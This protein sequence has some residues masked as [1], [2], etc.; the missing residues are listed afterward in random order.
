MSLEMLEKAIKTAIKR[1]DRRTFYLG[2]IGIR[3]DGAVVHAR[4]ES[5]EIPTPAVHAEAR[6]CRK[7]G[8]NASIIYVARYSFGRDSWAMA[9]PCPHCMAILK[10]HK[11][12]EI[13]YTT[14][15]NSFERL[16]LH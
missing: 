4:N 9:K 8:K 2:A 3:S 5:A 16:V 15:P 7:L 11:V 14:G 12:K 13:V 10:A 6:L 1:V